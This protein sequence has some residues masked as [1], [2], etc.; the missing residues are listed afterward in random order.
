MRSILNRCWM[1]SAFLIL[2][3][4]AGSLEQ[5]GVGQEKSAASQQTDIEAE[6]SA[7]Y[8]SRQ[9]ELTELADK[10][11]EL[12]KPEL[13]EFTRRWI[14]N[15]DP[16]REYFFVLPSNRTLVFPKATDR[17][18]K[19]WLSNLTT[20][21]NEFAA[22]LFKLAE[23]A[24]QAKQDDLAFRLLHEC[25]FHD[26]KH[27]ASA[28]ILGV[29]KS[30]FEVRA[31]AYRRKEKLYPDGKVVKYESEHFQLF[32]S[33][34]EKT[35][36]KALAKFERWKI[37][38][39]QMFYNYWAHPSWLSRRFEKGAPPKGRTKKYKVVLFS[40]RDEYIAKLRSV[41]PGIEVSVGYYLFPERT[42]FFYVGKDSVETTW[43][44]ELTH[45][46]M[47]ETIPISSRAEIRNSI[48]AVEGIAMF[49]ESLVDFGVCVTVGGED[50]ERLN[51]CRYNYF[52][53][54]FFVEMKR[55]N[56]MT[57]R[58]FVDSG[59]IKG[60]YSLSA[61]YCHYLLNP[62]VDGSR[63]A[64]LRSIKKAFLKFL[65]M[66]H[67]GKN[68]EVFFER[69]A[70]QVSF[71]KGF[72]EFLKP[73]RDRLIPSLIT[74][75]QYRILYLGNSDIGDEVFQNLKNASQLQTLDL[76][77]TKVT[78]A[79]LSGLVQF[80]ALEFLSLERTKVTNA[81]LEAIGKLKSLEELDL[82][83]TAVTDAGIQKLAGL[84][85]LVALW[86]GGTNISDQSIDVIASLSSLKQLDLRKTEVSAGGKKRLNP[87]IK[88]V[89]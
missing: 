68:A 75:D 47:H 39:R 63:K 42:S 70:N 8:Q 33:L 59:S 19:F 76:S 85:K 58:D 46:F 82:T 36:K 54:G 15:R 57:Q 20:R 43:V 7:L 77:G 9:K 79:G 56:A 53:R 32:T 80:T 28:K 26:P 65:Q 31:N 50:A 30:E 17:V 4:I 78:D 29:D 22:K 6:Y 12:E 86:L 5:I 69:V 74:P 73:E 21:N 37:V 52:R 14:P 60:L 81:S 84:N 38:W 24:Q 89:D 66:V 25:L 45:Q 88:L 23:K 27:A 48:W 49:M 67:Q 1:L 72:K 44:H 16:S 11:V 61:A 40:S 51:F 64:E 35:A 18:S 34:D 13:A 87:R 55:L 83:T 71:E 10:C 3:F 2:S 41:S 62:S